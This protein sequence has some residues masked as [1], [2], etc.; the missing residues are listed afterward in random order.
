MLFAV[1]GM[2]KQP[3]EA[4]QRA[5]VR[6]MMSSGIGPNYRSLPWEEMT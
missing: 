3:W 1:A 6:V 4:D 2:R 5:G